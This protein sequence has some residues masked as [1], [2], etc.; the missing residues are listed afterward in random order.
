LYQ[1]RCPPD[2]KT[3][4]IVGA[5]ARWNLGPWQKHITNQQYHEN[6]KKEK[7]Q[8]EAPIN[9]LEGK[10]EKETA[11]KASEVLEV[12]QVTCSCM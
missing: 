12:D 9:E 3:I 2:R 10:E 8:L 5:G 1:S 7:Y 11:I 6:T 4:L